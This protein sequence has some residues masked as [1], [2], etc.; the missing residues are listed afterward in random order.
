MLGHSVGE[1]AAACLAGVFSLEDG[2]RLIAARGRLVQKLPGGAMLA[3][4]KPAA[5]IEKYLSA[6][7]S[8]AAI[9]SPNACTVSGTFAAIQ[10]LQERLAADGIAARR[11]NTSHAFHSAMLDPVLPEFEALLQTIPLNAPTIPYLSNVTGDWITA[12]QATD[13]KYWVRHLRDTV[14][15]ADGM[16]RLL[17]DT[18]NVLLEV[19]PGRILSTLARQQGVAVPEHA[20]L[21]SLAQTDESELAGLA[22]AQ[23]RLWLAGMETDWQKTHG[24]NSRR[25]IPLPT[26]PFERKKYWVE[27]VRAKHGAPKQAENITIG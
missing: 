10:A 6:E 9:N 13:P 7:L 24:G 21:A 2:L 4:R 11:L 15:F 23:G 3:V 26:Y 22:E 14:R 18:N 17:A 16:E 25:R 27:P 12:E 5:E 8:L 19:G 1:F 20:A